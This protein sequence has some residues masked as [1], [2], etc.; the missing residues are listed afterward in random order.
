MLDGVLTKSR[1]HRVAVGEKWFAA[2]GFDIIH[3]RLRIIW[4]QIAHVAELTKVHL[5]RDKFSVH[6]DLAEPSLVDQAGKLVGR[7]FIHLAAKICKINLAC[8]FTHNRSLQ[9]LDNVS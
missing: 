5:D 7:A 6:I 9:S 2:A 4:T 8:V 3:D 1:I